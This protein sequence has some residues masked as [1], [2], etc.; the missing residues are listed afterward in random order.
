MKAVITTLNKAKI[1]GALKA[2]RLLGVK[3]T[4]YI[5]VKTSIEQPLSLK[6]TLYAA[7]ERIE[8]VID[9]VNADYYVAIEGGVIFN[10]LYPIEG[11]VAIV[12]DK[13]KRASI[14]YSSLFP[15][16]TNFKS[17]LSKNKTLED[18]MYET[19]KIKKIGELFGAIGYLSKGRMT[20][21]ELSY[22]AVLTAVLPFINSTLY[23]NIVSFDYLKKIFKTK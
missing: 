6:D 16:P 11:Q 13:R 9:K 18:L 20:R 2:L 1:L 14:G 7:I 17:M 3:N 15:L 21:I 12:V 5:G 23:G 10:L 4:V 8:Y 19:T 22:Q